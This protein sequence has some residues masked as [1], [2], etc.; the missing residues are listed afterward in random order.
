MIHRF[1]L[2]LPLLL[3]VAGALPAQSC[4]PLA[5]DGLDVGCCTHPAPILPAFPALASHASFASQFNPSSCTQLAQ[6]PL[7]VTVG[8]PTATSCDEFLISVSAINGADSIAGVM[9]AKYARTFTY[10]SGQVWRFLL[11][12]DLTFDSQSGTCPVPPCEPTYDVVHV[13]GSIDYYCGPLPSG[14]VEWRFRLDLTHHISCIHHGAARPDTSHPGTYYTL[15][16]PTPATHGNAALYPSGP[17]WDESIRESDL[18]LQQ[19]YGEHDAVVATVTDVAAYVCGNRTDQSLVVNSRCGPASTSLTTKPQN[20]CLA[21]GAG[22]GTFWLG[23]HGGV[24]GE[25]PQG[26]AVYSQV[27]L[28]D[29]ETWQCNLKHNAG[30]DLISHGVTTYARETADPTPFGLFGLI[31]GPPAPDFGVMF[32]FADHVT[33]VPAGDQVVPAFGVPTRSDLVVNLT[34]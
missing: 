9:Y 30:S 26:L 19:C 29:Y 5:D 17:Y 34:Q 31:I 33:V 7:D 24:F 25:F 11:N 8:T 20:G 10:E 3:T 14:Q 32:D 6:C 22:M 16:A 15:M 13:V 28:H 4:P 21:Q 12:G 23:L 27:L 2:P 1:A 18:V